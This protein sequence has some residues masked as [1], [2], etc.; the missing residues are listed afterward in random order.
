VTV[1]DDR[2]D[3][4]T[5]ESPVAPWWVRVRIMSP[6]AR[7][8]VADV[9]PATG[10]VLNQYSSTVAVAGPVPWL[11]VAVPLT[12]R[13]GR[14]RLLA[15]DLDA[16]RG[17]VEADQDRLMGWLDAAGVEYLVCESGPSGGRH[18]WAA[19]GGDGADAGLVGRLAR[20]LAARLATLDICPLTNPATGAVRPPGAPHRAGGA[21]RVLTGDANA[22][23]RA[24]TT[25]LQMEALYALVGPPPAPST[26][27]TRAAGTAIDE[28]GHPHL[29]GGRRGLPAVSRA[30]AETPLAAG[31][32]ASSVAW[33]VL[34]GAA[35]ARWRHGTVA[36]LAATAP[37]LEHL[38]SE[39]AP[40][41]RRPRS[42]PE[43]QVLLARQWAK[44]VQAAAAAGDQAGDGADDSWVAR[45][46]VVVGLVEV[47]QAKASVSLGRWTRPGGP[48]D[49][50]TLDA[51][52]QV[53][54]ATVSLAVDL[55]IRTIAAMT[56]L[57]RETARVSL[58]RLQR[59]GWIYQCAPAA[60]PYA[61]TWSPLRPLEAMGLELVARLVAASRPPAAQAAP[62]AVTSTD[63][64]STDPAI[65]GR[66]HVVPPPQEGPP[67]TSPA[68][69]PAPGPARAA[70]T[71]HLS[72]R[73]QAQAHDVFTGRHP[74]LG[75]AAGAVWAR[76]H[77]LSPAGLRGGTRI[78]DLAEA[79]GYDEAATRAIVA[80]LVEAGLVREW[81]PSLGGLWR[82]ASPRAR[83]TVAKRLGVHGTLAARRRAAGVDRE[84]WAW[85]QGEDAWMHTKRADRPEAKAA[86]H[87][88]APGPGQEHIKAA[89]GETVRARR[90]PYPRDEEGR[91][92]HRAAR[93]TVAR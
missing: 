44:A 77:E 56:G 41:G 70:L 37:G 15:F 91:A 12:D 38:R 85:W 90:G 25:E 14:Y 53:M 57:S 62:E 32:D 36:A 67:R 18:V 92:D 75:H 79:S 83:T 60:G 64:L 50:R 6:R 63:G 45:A 16:S 1:V 46:G 68:A 17:P 20:G 29:L 34:L 89:A 28:Q 81:S 48:A 93:A 58:V 78:E 23:V 13:A 76:L 88:R 82:A 42:A 69:L 74:A 8:R 26:P 59:D 31:A 2:P 27:T 3:G 54:L 33:T 30:A 43:R 47:T 55:D 7:V 86:R 9:D 73:L 35:R 61:A 80:R 10:E 87:R 71:A 66:S 5:C 19:I 39:A 65:E 52:C 21:S 40:S 4:V 84:V 51:L 11:P 22:L 24:G 49:R 72:C